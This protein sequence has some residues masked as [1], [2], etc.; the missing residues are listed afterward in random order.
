MKKEKCSHGGEKESWLLRFITGLKLEACNFISVI[1]L[2]DEASTISSKTE[3][4]LSKI[5]R[6]LNWFLLLDLQQRNVATII[7]EELF[8]SNH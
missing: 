4:A 6:L 3:G 2:H 1:S 8:Y 7:I 5:G